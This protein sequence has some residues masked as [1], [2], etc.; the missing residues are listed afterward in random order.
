MNGNSFCAAGVPPMMRVDAAFALRGWRE[1]TVSATAPTAAALLA[2][3]M[4]LLFGELGVNI[5]PFMAC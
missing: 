1:A 5:R 3:V 4:P 2:R